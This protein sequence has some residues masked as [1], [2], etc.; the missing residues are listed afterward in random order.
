MRQRETYRYQHT[1]EKNNSS[2]YRFYSTATFILHS[3]L[4]SKKR[5]Q[6]MKPKADGVKDIDVK[7]EILSPKGCI[8]ISLS[9][10]F[11]TVDDLSYVMVT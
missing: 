2:R 3:W 4:V 6:I 1:N 8:H 11:C 7:K 9:S 5:D 10:K